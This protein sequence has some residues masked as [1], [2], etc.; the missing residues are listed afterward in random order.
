ME[1]LLGTTLILLVACSLAA[2]SAAALRVPTVLGYLAVGVV[3]G[4]SVS[5]VVAP[6]ETLDFLS[7]LGVALLR[8]R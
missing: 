5:G 1:D 6:G 3:L 4:P 2:V 8:V 7:E